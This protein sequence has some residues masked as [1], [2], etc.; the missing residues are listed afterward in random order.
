MLDAQR[1]FDTNTLMAR[2]SESGN[3]V[4]LVDHAR[5]R[6]AATKPAEP[7]PR[8]R[9][10]WLAA[11]VAVLVMM[12]GLIVTRAVFD[13]STHSTGIAEQRSILLEDGSTID[14]G[15]RSKV[16]VSYSE[17]ARNLELLEGQALFKVA[18]DPARP[19]VV[20]TN[21]VRVRAVGTQFDVHNKRSGTVVT[22]LEGSVALL[23]DDRPAAGGTPNLSTSSSVDASNE[24]RVGSDA[25]SAPLTLAAG[26]QAIVDVQSN[27]RVQSADLAAATAWTRRQFVFEAT[28]LAEVADEFNRYNKRRLVVRDASL[29][30]LR[31][32]GVFSA[33]DTELF[34][35]FLRNRPEILVTETDREIQVS[36]Q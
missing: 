25:A 29:G 13:G 26:E 17:R 4:S 20:A 5:E 6:A 24:P 31:I 18:K 11:S 1:Q 19:F 7:H 2:V 34:V 8:K 9:R 23:R 32:S 35:R 15:A 28:P 12:V 27:A 14:L 22:V 33:A 10:G 16:R 3:V 36:R 30:D 21:G